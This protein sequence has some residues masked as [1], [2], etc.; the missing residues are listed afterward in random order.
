MVDRIRI[1]SILLFSC[2]LS[3]HGQ[4][5]EE[6]CAQY[7][8]LSTISG[9]GKIREKSKN[10]W[11][12]KFEG[13]DAKKA[14]LSRPHFAM[15][16][17]KGNI[18]IADKDANAIRKV[19]LEGIIST[20]AGTGKL[21]FNGDGIATECKLSRPNGLWVQPNGVVFILDLGNNRIRKLDLAGQ[22]TTVFED[23]NGISIGRGLYVNPSA[24]SIFYSCS[25]EIR[26][27]VK[28][29]KPKLF[30]DGFSSLGNIVMNS[31]NQLVVTDRTKGS[32][33]KIDMS[34]NKTIIA[35]KGTQHVI[36]GKNPLKEV[37]GVWPLDNGAY[38][39]GCHAGSK[40]WYLN[41][42]GMLFEFLDG[43]DDHSHKGDG[44]HFQTKGNKVSEI[45]S[46]TID[47]Q[48]N[49]I[50]CENDYGYIRKI[51]KK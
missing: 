20:V 19:D 43:K 33:Y 16:D 2:L 8:V 35:G 21:G 40:L 37:R 23:K 18:Y 4:E 15:A 44:E 39:L 9:K 50:I 25:S 41:S 17:K 13:N 11:E 29:N 28:G 45:R 49:I 38:L 1:V 32:V 47:H 7:N 27:W 22:L 6:F 24:D 42:K 10:G 12:E 36:D 26:I 46:V 5:F 34:G 51:K 48:G 30:M 3:V 14:E 31:N